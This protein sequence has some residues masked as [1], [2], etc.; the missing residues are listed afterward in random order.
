MID[1]DKVETAD[2]I[3]AIDNTSHKE[4][5]FYGKSLLQLMAYGYERPRGSGYKVLRI[6]LDWDS[7]DPE[8][9]ADLCVKI[10]G[11][12]DVVLNQSR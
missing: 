1:S 5:I 9:L 2:L 8:I 6:A 3:I 11:S 10:K 4:T 12:C 7:E